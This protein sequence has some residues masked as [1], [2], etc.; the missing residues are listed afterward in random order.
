MKDL[1]KAQRTWPRSLQTSPK[2]RIVQVDKDYG[3]GTKVVTLIRDKL[4]QSA[5]H[6]LPI[7]TTLH[8]PTIPT[9]PSHDLI[10][11]VDDDK[12][13]PTT[14]ISD[15]LHLHTTHPNA[16]LGHRG[17]RIKPDL[18]WGV[19]LASISRHVILSSA[20]R[21]PYKVGILTANDGYLI[22]PRFF[23]ATLL[24]D[25]E[26]A[27][28]GAYWMD[29]VWVNGNL[30]RSGVERFVVPGSAPP[31]DAVTSGGSV[32]DGDMGKNGRAEA[33]E[34]VLRWFKNDW[35]E[36]LWYVDEDGR[37]PEWKRWWEKPGVWVR[38]IRTWIAV[39]WN[40]LWY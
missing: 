16:A 34:E 24:L 27:P 8:D 5:A 29:D 22:Q 40:R 36:G 14:C 17:W 11:V 12:Y 26:N 15:L 23:N 21:T 18:T 32:I 7:P 39:G 19:P 25:Y 31:V 30:A 20:I 3:P 13:Y 2:I 1:H 4:L 6:P 38:W 37:M 28:R 33:N 35:E 10:L 9:D